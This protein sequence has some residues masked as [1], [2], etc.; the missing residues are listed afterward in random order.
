MNILVCIKR[1]PAPGRSI[2]LSEDKQ[3]IITRNLGFTISPHEECAIEEALRIKE[4]NGGSVTVLT[5]GPD[6][7]VE[8]LRQ[9]M[10][11]GV[12]EAILLQ[13]DGKEWD[14]M[15]TS[16]AIAD[17]IADK[18][19][20]LLLFGNESAD[21]GGYQVGSRVAFAK[22]FPFLSGVKSLHVAE[23]KAIAS[24]EALHA[25]EIYE[26]DLPAAIS[27]K[28]GINLPRYPSL[29]GRMRARRKEITI[30]KPAPISGGPEKL[31]LR[32]PQGE[33]NQVEVLGYG[34]EAVPRVME[35]LQELNFC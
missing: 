20:D 28:E 30:L 27:V 14:P 31:Q 25:R 11:Q 29:P 13:T 33:E 24:R 26:I 1:V 35:V 2:I 34:V 17:A 6:T 23:G 32:V 8:Q 18:D 7:A 16:K 12:D 22:D 4:K 15:A 5:L 10:A 21:S 19:F 3:E 9:A